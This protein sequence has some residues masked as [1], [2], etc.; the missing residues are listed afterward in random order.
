MPI[1][2]VQMDIYNGQMLD[3]HTKAAYDTHRFKVVVA[4]RK[5]RKTTFMTNELCYAALTDPRGLVYP[6]IAPFRQQGKEIVWE[7]HLAK[8]LA[9]CYKFGIQFEVNRSELTVKFKGGSTFQVAGA[10]NAE[11]LRGK[12]NWGG[13][14]LDEYGS[15]KP[16]IWQEIIR[17]NLQVHKAWGIIG[18][19]PKGF[20]HFYDTAKLGD[21]N[22]VI[23][24][25]LLPND[26]DFITFHATSY[27][28]PFNEA[29][30]IESAKRNTTVDFFN[31]EYL[32]LF[33]KFTGL[34][35]PEFDL[36]RHVHPIPHE[37]NEHADYL[38]G[39]DFAVRGFTAAIPI[40]IKTDGDIY[41]LDNYKKENEVAKNHIP[42]IKDMLEIYAKLL[43][44]MGYA[45]P[46]GWAKN[47]QDGEMVW[48]IAD[49]YLEEDMPITR[50]NNEVVAGI[51]YVRQL[52]KANKIHIDPRATDLIDELMQYQ[53]KDQNPNREGLQNAPEEVRKVNDHLVDALR[54]VLYSKPGAAEEV[55]NLKTSPFKVIF[56]PPRI[57]TEEKNPQNDQFEEI[58]IASFMDEDQQTLAL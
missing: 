21:H 30:E 35:Y 22:N 36:A 13:I 4:G 42:L 8:V 27:D 58:E 55:K 25:K 16:Y 48:S 10:D 49:E 31:Q 14:G 40:K 23:D 26:P 6:Y 9:L 2:T 5:A 28:N 50:A 11:A 1:K 47:Q 12:S 20:N 46:A 51:N 39:L 7:D 24:S 29:S 45:D 54:Y 53:W 17:P 33:T 52:F 56:G 3:W 37:F 15:W 32:A 43:T 19:T 44:Y 57:E 38:F 34:V 18:G 41:V